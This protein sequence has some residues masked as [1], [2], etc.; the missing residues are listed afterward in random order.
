M[1]RRGNRDRKARLLELENIGDRDEFPT[2][3]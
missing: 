3:L 2:R 1:R